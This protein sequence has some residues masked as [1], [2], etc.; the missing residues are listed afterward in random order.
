VQ[1]YPIQNMGAFTAIFIIEKAG[2]RE[3]GKF[4]QDE[5]MK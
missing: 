2:T 3:F 5:N 1:H 4:N